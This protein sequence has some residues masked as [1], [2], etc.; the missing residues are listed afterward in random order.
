MLQ[1]APM[2][3][4]QT[5]PASEQFPP[6]SLIGRYSV[7]RNI[8]RGGMGSVY[9]ARHL[10]LGKRVA[11]KTLLPEFCAN[12]AVRARFMREGQ[13]ASRIRHAHVADVTDVGEHLG[14][15]FLVMEF[16]EGEDLSVLL[17]REG[18]LS[19]ER[20][21]ELLIPVI[22][23]VQTAHEESV[24][25][26]DLKPAN[27]FLARDRYGN[28]VPKVL[29]FGV[30]KLTDL[31]EDER[32]G[33]TGTEALL[34]TPY[35][36][37]P[38]QIENARSIGPASDQWAL[39][40]VLYACLTRQLPFKGPSPFATMQ[41]I[42]MGHCVSPRQHVP[43]IP[44]HLEATIQRTFARDPNARFPSLR[45]LGCEL[46]P[47]LTPDLQP[48]WRSM[49]GSVQPRPATLAPPSRSVQPPA[50]YVTQASSPS[51]TPPMD[52]VATVVSPSSPQIP[53]F[54]SPSSLVAT[55]RAVFVPQA[56]EA[57]PQ[58]S[59]KVLIV[60][61]A[62]VAVTSLLGALAWW[63]SSGTSV[64]VQHTAAPPVV[65][66]PV[67][68]PPV[69]TPPVVTP[70]VVTPPVVTPPVVTPPVVTPPVVT[71]PVVTQQREI[72]PQQNRTGRPRT[73]NTRGTHV[74]TQA[75]RPERTTGG[76]WILR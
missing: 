62:V 75:P 50:P 40:V 16:L 13:A 66:P 2:G 53:S 43:S 31:A 9:E 7:V 52:F 73:N 59:S 57:P 68:A 51:I 8:G 15:P 38:E 32:Q 71:P 11:I 10:D 74:P 29:D 55:S 44:Q 18:P 12:D 23:A 49:F 56:T 26:R 35:Y 19:T 70:P 61:M 63:R 60:V 72:R 69:V 54:A 21:A 30:S 28:I 67:V 3:N 1:N 22:A 58:Q 34:G 39:G 45:E 27:I 33:L 20:V 46:F 64:P 47:Y 37:A 76:N 6:G 41:A 42:V 24:V 65:T 4:E 36:M 17:T 5:K 14:M 25:H 48:H